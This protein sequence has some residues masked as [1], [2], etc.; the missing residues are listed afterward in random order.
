LIM[1]ASCQFL[2]QET[3]RV[4]CK[5]PSEQEFKS[6]TSAQ[7]PTPFVTVDSDLQCQYTLTPALQFVSCR[8]DKVSPVDSTDTLFE[9]WKV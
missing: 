9:I 3:D 4:Q 8:V 5:Y 2:M 7:P 6:A 1:A